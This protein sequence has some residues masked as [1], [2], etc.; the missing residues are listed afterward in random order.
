MKDLRVALV[1]MCFGINA[2][3]SSGLS[4]FDDLIFLIPPILR[5]CKLYSVVLLLLESSVVFESA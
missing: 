5:M 1:P 2:E 3:I 4:A